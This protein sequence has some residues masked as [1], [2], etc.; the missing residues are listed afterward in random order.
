MNEKSVEK[1]VAL[2]YDEKRRSAP[3][4]VASGRGEVAARI[5]EVARRE[6]VHI[7]EDPDLVEILARIPLGDDIPAEVYRAVA[8]VLAFVYRMNGRYRDRASAVSRDGEGGR[9]LD[10]SAGGAESLYP[11]EP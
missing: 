11:K 7:V 9:P 10:E 5:V 8:E 3:H 4:V 6:G 1:A 2:L